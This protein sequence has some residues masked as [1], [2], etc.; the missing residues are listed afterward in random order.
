MTAPLGRS[1]SAAGEDVAPDRLA[2]SLCGGKEGSVGGT[3]EQGALSGLVGG[4][5]V[6]ADM[7]QSVDVD[8]VACRLFGRLV[9]VQYVPVVDEWSRREQVGLSGVDDRSILRVLSSMPSDVSLPR[10]VLTHGQVRVL[11]RAPGGVCAMSRQTITRLLVPALRVRRVTLTT[12]VSEASLRD[13]SRFA[14]FAPQTLVSTRADVPDHLLGRAGLLG[15]EVR[16]SDGAVLRES[17]WQRP[18]RHTPAGWLFAEM[19]TAQVLRA[20]ALF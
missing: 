13:L 4:Q 5:V 18:S 1:A 3:D 14:P 7:R 9:S 12:V 2:A 19:V 20:P 8:A 17:T 6:N 11:R 15:I 16:T 10:G